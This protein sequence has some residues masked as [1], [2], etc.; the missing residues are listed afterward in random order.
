MLKLKSS[1]VADARLR[2]G[3]SGIPVVPNPRNTNTRPSERPLCIQ[4]TYTACYLDCPPSRTSQFAPRAYF[5]TPQACACISNGAASTPPS[6]CRPSFSDGFATLS[7]EGHRRSFMLDRVLR[8]WL[9][10]GARM[11]NW[12][13]NSLSHRQANDLN[14]IRV[15]L[16]W[17]QAMQNHGGG[18]L[19]T[20]SI[21][22]CVSVGL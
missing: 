7:N 9:D 15:D 17:Y 3:I 20:C 14:W 6:N 5:F 21:Q 11:Q 16:K 4:N 12:I 2:C 10:Y 19:Y 22:G 13:V 8:L 1:A 18:D